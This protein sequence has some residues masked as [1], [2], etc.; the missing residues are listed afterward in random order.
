MTKVYFIDCDLYLYM[1]SSIILSQGKFEP[2]NNKKG[3][4]NLMEQKV[5]HVYGVDFPIC[6]RNMDSTVKKLN[7]EGFELTFITTQSK[8]ND[9]AKFTDA[10]LVFTK[11]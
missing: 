10:M 3:E 2:L 11:K 6:A 4:A 9:P 7:G 5:E 1:K 8:D